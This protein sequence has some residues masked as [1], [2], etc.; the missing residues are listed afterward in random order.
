MP[1]PKAI[2]LVFVFSSVL[3]SSVFATTAIGR[4]AVIGALR[5]ASAPERVV[6]IRAASLIDGVA[7]QTQHNVLI[8]IR[9]N[10]IGERY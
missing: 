7:A 2:L 10:K 4:R 6:A 3:L 9:G 1:S 5:G 8:V